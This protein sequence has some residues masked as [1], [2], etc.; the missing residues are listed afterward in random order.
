MLPRRTED[1]RTLLWVGV[2]TPAL[3][4]VQ[5]LAPRLNFILLP[6]SCYF[7]IATGVIAHNHM[8]RPTLRSKWANELFSC[9]ISVFYGYPVFAWLPTHNLNHHRFVNK[10]GDAT[11]T[12]RYT[13]QHNAWVAATYFFVSAYFQSAWIKNYVLDARLNHRRAFRRIVAQYALTFGTQAA[14]L[15]L[16]VNLHGLRT[17]LKVWA[18]ALGIPAFAALWTIMLFNYIQHVHTDP[19]SKHD[20]SRNFEGRL[21]NFLLFGNGYHTVHHEQ[22]TLHWAD[23]AAAHARIQPLIDHRLRHRSMFELFFKQYLLAPI[24]PALGTAQVG[25]A[26]FDDAG[27]APDRNRREPT[28]SPGE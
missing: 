13:N 11:I 26:P 21:L 7:A 5:Y 6:L 20:H 27:S 15:A 22:A 10:R 4:V 23:A 9:W 28:L 19:W 25:R 24:W 12:W 2:F 17:G 8:H 3:V 14:A 1:Y 16:A 18:C